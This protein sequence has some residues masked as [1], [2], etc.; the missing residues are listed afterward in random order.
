MIKFITTSELGRLRDKE[1]NVYMS[2]SLCQEN[3]KGAEKML[4]RISGVKE[5]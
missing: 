5:S 1:I 2:F 4:L 3:D